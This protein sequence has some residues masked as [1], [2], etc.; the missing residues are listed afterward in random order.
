MELR[1]LRYFTAVV[2]YQ[3]YREASRQLR[4]AQ[5]AISQTVIDLE[6]EI[7]VPLFD[8]MGRAVKLTVHGKVFYQEAQRTLSQASFAVE[9]ARQSAKS[10]V[11]KLVIGF[12]APVTHSF[13]PDVVRAFKKETL[14]TEVVLRD[15]LPDELMKSLKEGEIDV[16]LT[17]YGPETNLRVS[18]RTLYGEDLDIAVPVALSSTEGVDLKSLAGHRFAALNDSGATCLSQ[19]IR[20]LYR[21][22]G[23]SPETTY[24]VSSI[25]ALFSL[26]EAEQAVAIVPASFRIWANSRI[27]FY[28][29]SSSRQRLRI[30]ALRRSNDESTAVNTF[31]DLLE[32]HSLRIQEMS[33]CL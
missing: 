21:D 2:D 3:G 31:F 20:E 26:V 8:R 4:V 16:A 10:Y 11:D 25:Q 19:A 13:L 7:G 22:A 18:S 32:Q 9:A 1:H 12:W 5:P 24:E 29:I 14:A 27:C 6:Q 30:A 15:L 33:Q 23:F 28:P 17:L